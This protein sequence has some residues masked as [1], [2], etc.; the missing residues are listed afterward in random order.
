MAVLVAQLQGL[1]RQRK[2]LIVASGMKG[3]P[4]PHSHHSSAQLPLPTSFK[5]QKSRQIEMMDVDQPVSL[6]NRTKRTTYNAR[7]R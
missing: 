6:L 7:H 4:F 3:R 1:I 5:R 2:S